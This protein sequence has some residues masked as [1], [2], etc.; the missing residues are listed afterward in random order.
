MTRR[1]FLKTCG[2]ARGVWCAPAW[3]ADDFR[4]DPQQTVSLLGWDG[5]T[6]ALP[7]CVNL[8]GKGPSITLGNCCFC[9]RIRRIASVKTAESGPKFARLMLMAALPHGPPERDRERKAFGIG[10]LGIWSFSGP[11]S[12]GARKVYGRLR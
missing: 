1:N 9:W 12:E 2:L 8:T 4:L 10:V 3:A 11:P 6:A 5:G 7:I